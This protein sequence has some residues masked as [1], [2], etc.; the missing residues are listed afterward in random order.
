MLWLIALCITLSVLILVLII[1]L[2]LLYKSMDEVETELQNGLEHDTNTLLTISSRDRHMRRFVDTL[3]QKL[4]VY[5][6]Q[7]KK[8][9]NGNVELENA[10]TNISHDLRTP[11]TA[12][13]GYLDLLEKEPQSAEVKRYLAVIENRTK[14]LET[15]TEELF[16]YSVI[17]SSKEELVYEEICL[18]TALEEGI[19]EYYP[20]LKKSGITPEIAI[21]NQIVLRSLDKNALMRIIGNILSNAI[22]YSEGDLDIRL[23]ENGTIIFANT[24]PKLNKAET[25]K[26]FDRFYTVETARNSTGLGLSIAKSLVEKMHGTI[27]AD[28]V[29][30]KLEI[31]VEFD[32]QNG[33]YME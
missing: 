25:A 14:A 10:V 9:Q 17:T 1:K 32:C 27:G 23:L 5:R 11:L 6:L 7:R 8:Y 12:I 4:K 21:T 16:R 22:K 24:A 30:G 18:N 26:L 13:R 33:V 20:P 2:L 3:N 29:N 15:L 19:A 28:Y 31:Q